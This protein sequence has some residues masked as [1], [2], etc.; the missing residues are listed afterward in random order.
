MR[1]SSNELKIL[2]TSDESLGMP[3]FSGSLFLHT[4]LGQ[5]FISLYLGINLFFR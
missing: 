1:I 5:Q 4:Q 2:L 3:A